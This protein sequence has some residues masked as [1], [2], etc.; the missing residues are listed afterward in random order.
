MHLI[1]NIKMKKSKK[2]KFKISLEKNWTQTDMGKT[3][4]NDHYDEMSER[5]AQFL[6]WQ[7]VDRRTKQSSKSHKKLQNS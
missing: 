7:P 2:I 1:F 6:A 5:N 4:N 3:I